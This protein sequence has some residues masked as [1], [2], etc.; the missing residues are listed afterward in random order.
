M[1]QIKD[2]GGNIQQVHSTIESGGHVP[3]H[4][5]TSSALPSGASTEATLALV[6]AAVET[7]GTEVTLAALLTELQAKANPTDDQ[8]VD[9]QSSVLPT[10]ASTEATLALAYTELQ[11][12]VR[13]ITATAIRQA[14]GPVASTY[15]SGVSAA[16]ITDTS[17]H[18]LIAAPTGSARI[19]VTTLIVSNAHGSTPTWVHLKSASTIIASV[20][21]PAL[22]SIAVPIS[23]AA[24]I[25]CA[26]DEALN[27]ACA[28][29]S[30]AVRVTAIGYKIVPT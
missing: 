13:E 29:A 12:V 1:L 18:E 28:T 5:V 10:G 23:T 7:L 3:H 11:A 9:V 24:P 17:D 27:V 16:D 21:A 14:V 2:A 19:H 25:R 30:T 22:S 4:R 26:A 15:V 6:R 20:F 8:Y